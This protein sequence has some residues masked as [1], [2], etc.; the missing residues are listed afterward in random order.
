[1]AGTFFHSGIVCFHHFCYYTRLMCY[2]CLAAKKV[3]RSETMR[4]MFKGASSLN[5]DL[6]VWGQRALQNPDVEGIFLDTACPVKREPLSPGRKQPLIGPWCHDCPGQ[7]DG[8]GTGS[9][10]A[11]DR[12]GTTTMAWLLVMIGA[13]IL[14]V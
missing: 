11:S 10:A 6:C 4:N 12:C 9:S 13:W 5:Q 3:N 7:P 2:M 8:S 14:A 1:M